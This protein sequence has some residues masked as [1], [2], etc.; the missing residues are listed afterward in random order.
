MER[1]ALGDRMKGYYEDRYRASLPRRTNTIIR[2]DGKA[3]HT[4]TRGLPRPFCDDFIQTMQSTAKYMCETIQGVK[5][6]YVQSDE[7]S[8]WLTDYDD[9]KTDAWF[10]GN[11][12]K[13]CSVSAATATVA[14]NQLSKLG[15]MA[16]FDSRVFVIPELEEVVNYFIWRQ[17]DA[18]RNS[19]NTVAQSLYS[20]KELHGVTI[21]QAHELLHAKGKNWNDYPVSHKRGSCVIKQDGY[22]VVTEPPI[23]TADREFIKSR[24]E[25]PTP[26]NGGGSDV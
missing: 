18:E 26:A 9:I 5:L 2:V 11:I 10:D 19:I 21:Q 6:A 15:K 20:P 22:W 14:F 4:L 7:I 1:S 12:Q 24:A 3:F 13:I 16:L 8:L 25:H 23:F 17:K